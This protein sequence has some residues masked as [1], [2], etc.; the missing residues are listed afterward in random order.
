MI[1]TLFS[2]FFIATTLLLTSQLLITATRLQQEVEKAMGGAHLAEQILSKIRADA[3]QS[4]TPP[5]P[6]SGEDY[7]FPGYHYQIE[8]VRADL[9]SPCATTEMQYPV[10]ERRWIPN[11]GSHVKVTVTWNPP[12]PRNRSIA[13]G[14]IL[15]KL[16]KV[17]Q[18]NMSAASGNVL[19]V[20]KNASVQYTVNATDT[21]SNLVQGVFFHWYCQPETGNGLTVA[22]TRDGRR[23]EFTHIYKNPYRTSPV[24][25]PAG[26]QC[27]IRARARF[28]GKEFECDSSAITLTDL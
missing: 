13:Y 1:E 28:N 22:K 7:D 25:F 12:H 2:L 23:G 4:G 15:K 21:S 6:D 17:K 18:L 14:L 27:T 3:R 19:P 5:S 11:P 24:Y 20:T 16:P 9:Y 26:T 8:V 10:N